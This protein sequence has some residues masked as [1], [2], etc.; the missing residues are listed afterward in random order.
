M[1]VCATSVHY[2]TELTC[3]CSLRHYVGIVREETLLNSLEALLSSVKTHGFKIL[4]LEPHRKD[5]GVFVKFQYSAAHSD[6]ALVTIENDL[7]NQVAKGG[8][9][10]SW[11]GFKAGNVWL[12]KGTPWREVSLLRCG[13]CFANKYTHRI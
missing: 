4:A 9:A 12:V 5:G 8:G 1:G 2:D 10:P 7:K 3:A 11:T 13:L 6:E